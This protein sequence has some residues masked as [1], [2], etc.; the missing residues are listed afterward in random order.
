M[1]AGSAL[2][3]RQARFFETLDVKFNWRLVSLRQ[4]TSNARQFKTNESREAPWWT[5]KRPVPVCSLVLFVLIHA[6]SS[7]QSLKSVE[8]VERKAR[9]RREQ[10]DF[11]RNRTFEPGCNCAEEPPRLPW[12]PNFVLEDETLPSGSIEATFCR[13]TCGLS[14]TLDFDVMLLTRMYYL[15]PTSSPLRNEILEGLQDQYDRG[16]LPFWQQPLDVRRFFVSENHLIINLSNA[17][18]LQPLL[19]L[20]T[21]QYFR[22]E[23]SLMVQRLFTFCRLKLEYGF[24]E[25]FSTNYLTFTMGALLNLV[26]F[27]T[28]PDIQILCRL[29]ADRLIDEYLLLTTAEGMVYPAAGRNFPSNYRSPQFRDMAWFS[30]GLGPDNLVAGDIGSSIM[31]TSTY[32]FSSRPWNHAEDRVL[33]FGH[34]ADRGREVM[35]ELSTIDRVIFLWSAAAV[36]VPEI[37]EDFVE[38]AQGELMLFEAFVSSALP[39]DETSD[40][41]DINPCLAR[42][43]TKS[44]PAQSRGADLTGPLDIAIY[45][46]EGIALTSVLR[47]HLAGAR[48]FQQF[49]WAATVHDIAIWSQSGTV[50]PSMGGV[51]RRISETHMPFV[52]QDQH[53]ALLAYRPATSAKLPSK[54]LRSL[55]LVKLLADSVPVVADFVDDVLSTQ[56]AVHFPE[57]RF[58]EVVEDQ[59]WIFARKDVSYVGIWR[60][61]GVQ[62]NNCSE[63]DMSLPLAELECDQYFYFESTRKSNGQA[64]IAVVGNN[65]THGRFSQFVEHIVG[66]SSVEISNKIALISKKFEVSALIDGKALSASLSGVVRPRKDRL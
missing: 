54:L 23:P 34:G 13:I 49:S 28:D 56:V 35:P 51:I 40:I 44:L 5:M 24:Y 27:S 29:V 17:L 64:W 3:C 63:F 2:V 20:G 53:V 47:S 12:L 33:S 6:S 38:V 66:T 7:S 36:V 59:Q 57:F 32:S 11:Y 25:F 37:V 10:I 60:P 9:Y 15:A 62:F 58:E 43:V 46:N 21:F 50:G 26:E 48:S 19:N 52:D 18:L 8:E 65:A 55:K 22:S 39:Q 4:Y 30:T 45:K 1:L 61:D 16:N 14:T 41:P 31:A 42:L